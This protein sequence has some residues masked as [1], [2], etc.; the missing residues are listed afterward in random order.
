MQVYAPLIFEEC[1]VK[2][3]GMNKKL[4]SFENENDPEL[5][6]K[7]DPCGGLHP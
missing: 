6:R 7:I 1:Y 3:K 4:R 5:S 2:H